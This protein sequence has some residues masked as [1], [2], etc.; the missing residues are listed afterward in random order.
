MYVAFILICVCV[1][2]CTSHTHH[3]DA[4][5]FLHSPLLSCK[6]RRSTI[7][8]KPPGLSRRRWRAQLFS[9]WAPPIHHC[10]DWLL[11]KTWIAVMGKHGFILYI[12]DL[13][14]Y[15]YISIIFIHVCIKPT[16][17]FSKNAM[18][19]CPMPLENLQA[20][21]ITDW[22][23]AQTISLRSLFA[24]WLPLSE[25]LTWEMMCHVSSI[26]EQSALPRSSYC[27]IYSDC[28]ETVQVVYPAKLSGSAAV[29]PFLIWN[30]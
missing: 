24:I 8:R 20:T 3:T 7:T 19:S 26:T 14:I 4:S 10:F 21:F 13:F 29:L 6:L 5:K 25:Q 18:F 1:C 9:L 22:F 16:P 2:V 28:S 27:S 17:L 11:T 12:L 15:I 30:T 23:L